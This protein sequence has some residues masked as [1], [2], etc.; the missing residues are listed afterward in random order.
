[1]KRLSTIIIL[2]VLLLT[3]VIPVAA[4]PTA[5]TIPTFSITSVSAGKSV[6]VRTFNFPAN[7]VY[8]VTM[9]D[10]GT[11]GVGG[12]KVDT[13]DSGKGGSFDL[14]FKIPD[15]LA[16]NYQI[17]IRFQSSKTG[18]FAYNWFYNNTSGTGGVP[19][20]LPPWTYPTFSIVDVNPDKNVTI[21]TN[22]LPANDT[23]V[24]TMGPMGSRG[25]N[26]IKVDTIDSGSGGS[27]EYKFK[28]PDALKG[29]YQIAI[30][31]QSSKSG[32]FAFN[33]FYNDTSGTG[34]QPSGSDFGLAP[35]VFPTFSI[36][37]VVRDK[38]VTIRTSNLSK[39]DTYVVRM[40]PMG[41]RG[42][43]GIKVD[44]IDS[45]KGGTQELTFKIPSALAGSYQIAIR[46]ESSKSGYFAF[47]WFYNN[48]Y[49]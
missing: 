17:A 35:G 9:G 10:M 18:Y 36:I 14:T 29:S 4:A 42:V 25:I 7:D 49:P 33:W 2:I 13:I 44:T 28:I 38:S 12:I 20:P 16:D 23:F 5:S 41:S 26:G 6:S 45:G 47:N 8:V 15:A 34:G 31:L 24:V 30:R 3:S 43:N 27:K 22:N 40:G 11:R 48:T 32:Y 39:N 21:K 37:S 19:A 1:M 46:M